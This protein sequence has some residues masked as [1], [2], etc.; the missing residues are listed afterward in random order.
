M[1]QLYKT[2]GNKITI[3]ERLESN[4]RKALVQCPRCLSIKIMDYHK[5]KHRQL[6]TDVCKSCETIERNQSGTI[7]EARYKLIDKYVE[8]HNLSENGIFI[9]QFTQKREKCLV[10]CKLCNK[11][12]ESN[13]SRNLFKSKG[14][15]ECV[16]KMPKRI[17]KHSEYYTHRLAT[18]YNTLIQRVTNSNRITAKKY[19]QDKNISICNEWLTDRESFFRWSH[20]NGYSKELT[21]DRIDSNKNYEPSNCRWTTKTVQAR[22][23]ICIRSTNTSGYRGVS[24][25]PNKD[26]WRARIKVNTNETLIG[27]FDTA[28]EAAFAYD[29]YVLSHQLEHTRNFNL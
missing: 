4:S 19:Y 5:I 8:E 12:Y 22:N 18:I 14:C 21:I 17:Y 24:L 15:P 29:N 10:K 1:L 28:L 20:E 3:L 27:T 6:P 2:K 25:T 13:Y 11:E 26:K 23:T 9:I 16:K 7:T